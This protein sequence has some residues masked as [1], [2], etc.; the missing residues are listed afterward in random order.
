[1]LESSSTKSASSNSMQ[2]LASR[3]HADHSQAHD[4]LPCT[5]TYLQSSLHII[6]VHGDAIGSFQQNHT[7]SIQSPFE[8]TSDSPPMPSTP[9]PGLSSYPLSTPTPQSSNFRFTSFIHDQ[10]PSSCQNAIPIAHS[11]I[12]KL[13]SEAYYI[14]NHMLEGT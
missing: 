11:R 3:L 5:S 1:M 13:T 7:L 12:R 2:I 10:S 14:Y 8:I 4:N 9:S 6:H